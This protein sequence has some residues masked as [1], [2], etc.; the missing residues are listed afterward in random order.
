VV[1][2]GKTFYRRQR[3][4]KKEPEK[5]GEVTKIISNYEK[6]IK[7]QDFESCRAFDNDGNVIL[8]KNGERD[9]VEFNISETAK[10]EGTR[11]T[12][13]HPRGV[14]FSF[15]DIRFA[16]MTEMKEI[17]VISRKRGD[18]FSLKLKDGSN[19]TR[20]LWY[21]KIQPA[22]EKYHSTVREEFTIE[23]DNGRMAIGDA[24]YKHLHE[25][26]TRVANDIDEIIYKGE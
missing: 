8:R 2:G 18:T 17:R 12:H 21:S 11:F 4:G 10:L 5:G 9:H 14:S 20:E 15:K 1:R 19:L 23:I 24:E 7:D 25:V 22:A 13:N 26:W 16:C 6:N 3:V